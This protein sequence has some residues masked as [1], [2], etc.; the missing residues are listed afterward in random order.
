MPGTWYITCLPGIPYMYD[1]TGSSI[2]AVVWHTYM[3]R[4][5]KSEKRTF[6]ILKKARKQTRW[7]G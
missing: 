4:E 2:T 5:Y 3:R 6:P 7:E 1:R